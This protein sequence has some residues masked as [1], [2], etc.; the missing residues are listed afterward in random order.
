M[1]RLSIALSAILLSAFAGNALA[2]TAEI[3][4]FRGV[5]TPLGFTPPTNIF[6]GAPGTLICHIVRDSSGKV[7]SGSVTF[8]V[9][10]GFPGPVV[11]VCSRRRRRSRQPTQ[12]VWR[13]SRE[14]WQRQISIT[15]TSI[16][17]PS[18]TAPSGRN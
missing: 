10:Y 14:C 7:N 18:R 13:R 1:K 15:S 3:A 5:M 8:V 17:R 9:G 4:F 16:R 6:A 11:T 12:L 2:D